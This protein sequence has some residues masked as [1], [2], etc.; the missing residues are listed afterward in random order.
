MG[1]SAPI[2]FARLRL[3]PQCLQRFDPAIHYC[4]IFV[5]LLPIKAKNPEC[6]RLQGLFFSKFSGTPVRHSS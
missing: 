4:I 6:P 2:F 3:D 1:A 5:H